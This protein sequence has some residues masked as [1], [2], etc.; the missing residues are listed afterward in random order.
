MSYMI[1]RKEDADAMAAQYD[2]LHHMGCKVHDHG[3]GGVQGYII[4]TIN[5]RPIW[6]NGADRSILLRAHRAR[7]GR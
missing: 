1:E 2:H 4:R 5:G 7:T 6:L 3:R